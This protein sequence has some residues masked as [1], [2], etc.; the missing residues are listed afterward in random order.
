MSA[1]TRRTVR[2]LGSVIA[3]L[4]VLTAAYSAT[5][6]ASRHTGTTTHELSA[7][8]TSV[9]LVNDVGS[10][11]VVPVAAGERPRAVVTATGGFR[12][13]GVDVVG[14]GES[15]T[16]AGSCPSSVWFRPCDVQWQLHLPAD[17]A[18]SVRTSVGDVTVAGV[19]TT[20]HAETSVGVVT[21]DD[22]SAQTV[23]ALSSVGD[24]VVDVDVP[25]SDLTATTSTGNVV[26]T[27]PDG[28]T[29]YR[30]RSGTSIGTVTNSLPVDAA[31]PH[32]LEALTSI[33]DVTLR[34]GG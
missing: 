30:V 27:V 11:L 26:V 1:T 25:P 2:V 4:M 8:L 34:L 21:V 15:V 7:G 17:A 31:S 33:G 20:V 29:T 28:G 23:T 14:S 24:V 9:E 5:A 13:P 16:L 22:V 12:E 6:Q 19:G 10:V 18:V 32:R 3:L